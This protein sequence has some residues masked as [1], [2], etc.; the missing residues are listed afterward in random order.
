MYELAVFQIDAR[1]A[2]GASGI[3]GCEKNEIT[4]AKFGLVYT[5]TVFLVLV[6]AASM[7]LLSVHILIYHVG[8]TGTV[9]TSLSCASRTVRSAYPFG[10]LNH[11]RPIVTGLDVETKTESGTRQFAVVDILHS[12]AR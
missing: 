1:V 6:D 7:E 3:A 2:D 9:N 5:A 12:A 10:S 4:C 8:E 11:Q